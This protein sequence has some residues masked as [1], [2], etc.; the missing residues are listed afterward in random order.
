MSHL[1]PFALVKSFAASRFGIRIDFE[2]GHVF[3]YRRELPAS[4][5]PLL[6][7]PTFITTASPVEP[8]RSGPG[9]ARALPSNVLAFP[10]R[11]AG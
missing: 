1:N 11:R 6:E 9:L 10:A 2:G 3:E 4:E 5:P 7:P 8:P